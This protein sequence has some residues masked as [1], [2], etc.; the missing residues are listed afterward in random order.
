MKAFIYTEYGSPDVL[1]L[2]DI[3]KPTP[4]DDEV[5]IK[6]QAASVNAADWHLM[7]G[8][9]IMARVAFGLFK[10]KNQRLGADVAGVVE[11]VGRNVTQFR[12]GDEVFSDIS[13]CGWG[14]FAEYVCAREDMVVLKP[15]N[16]S[17]QEAAAVPLAAITALQGLR[18]KG[19]IQPGQKVLINGASG[20]VGAFA[21]QIAKA[22]GA[23]VTAVCSTSKIDMV[24][25]LGADRVIDYTKEDFTGQLYDLIFAANGNRSI[26]EYRRA[27]AP[28][29]ICVMAGGTN[30][31]IFQGLLLGPWLSMVGS[32]KMSSTLAKPN[33]KD[34]TILKDLIEAGKV[35]PI[36]DRCYPFSQT[37]DAIRH[38]EQGHAR[39]KIVISME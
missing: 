29:G 23:D 34:L 28:Q 26:L 22:F 13:A 21:V 16:L 32:K 9:P 5:L 1:Q 15:T 39:G 11:T 6:V 3:E 14:S 2:K 35:K 19:Q 25:S 4:K 27:L 7:R 38:L 30:K 24:R 18:D 31:Q 8:K 36:L 33:A 12:P 20:G 37:P 10:P 17:M